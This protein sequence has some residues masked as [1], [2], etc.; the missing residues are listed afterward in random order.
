MCHFCPPGSGSSTDSEY[1]SGSTDLIESGS[2]T[3]PDP[4]PC[5][6]FV[7]SVC[8]VRG[9]AAVREPAG[10]LRH[11]Q[12]AG[13]RLHLHHDA[14]R[15]GGPRLTPHPLHPLHPTVLLQDLGAGDPDLR[16]LGRSYRQAG[17]P[18]FFS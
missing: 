4:K 9:D 6:T 16:G 15:G 10:G 11:E 1:G 5:F 13:E 12:R 17:A 3:D 18:Y 2:S 14:P 7:K 8:L